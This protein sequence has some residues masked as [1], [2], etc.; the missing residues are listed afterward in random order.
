MS[1]SAWSSTCPALLRRLPWSARLV[2]FAASPCSCVLRLS[3][4]LLQQVAA[5]SPLGSASP[6]LYRLFGGPRSS[7]PSTTSGPG[8]GGFGVHRLFGCQGS[9]SVVVGWYVLRP[10]G[11]C[12]GPR[13]LPEAGW[14]VGAC[15]PYT[16]SIPRKPIACQ[17]VGERLNKSL[18]ESLWLD[19]Q[20]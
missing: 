17:G 20:Q 3:G 1:V 4:L 7:E 16:N 8:S 6:S 9:V 15:L 5:S 12:G 18:T 2:V 10:D 13:C 11:P 14:K 19:M